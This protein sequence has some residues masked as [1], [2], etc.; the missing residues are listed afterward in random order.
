[1]SNI[2]SR[3]TV[4]KR[5]KIHKQ[6]SAMKLLVVHEEGM[7]SYINFRPFNIFKKTRR[8][9]W[10]CDDLHTELGSSASMGQTDIFNLLIY[11]VDLLKRLDP[12]V[13]L[14]TYLTS[15][16]KSDPCTIE[17]KA[18]RARTVRSFLFMTSVFGQN[19]HIRCALWSLTQVK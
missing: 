1:M 13:H 14:T 15:A 6:A 9:A 18:H 7:I 2:W 12:K 16:L 11:M 3:W 17:A 10:G 4:N 19:K 8:G 5:K